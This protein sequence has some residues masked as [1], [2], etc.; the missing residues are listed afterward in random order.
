[1]S[2]PKDHH[3]LVVQRRS[4][5][6]GVTIAGA[7]AM[8]SASGAL[9]QTAGAKQ[10]APLPAATEPKPGKTVPLPN[11][12]AESLPPPSDPVTQTSSGGEFMVD[13]LKALN[14]EYIAINPASCFRGI[15][16]ALINYGKNT[17]PE[18]LTCTHEEIAVAMAHGYA[19]VEGRPMGVLTHGT[20]GLQHAAMAIYNAY[21]DKVPVYVMIGNILAADKRAAPVEWAHAAQD[22]ASIAR[23]YLKWDDQPQSLQHFAESAVR[24][25][26]LAVTAPM[27]PVLLSLD[28]EL[29]ENPIKNRSELKIPK[30]PKLIPAQADSGAVREVARLLVAA[31]NPVL[32]VD[33]VARTPAGMTSLV[34]LAES[35]QCAVV[36]KGGRTN[37]PSRHPLNLSGRAR[38]VIS[39]ADVIVGMELNDFWGSLNTFTDRIERTSASIIGSNAKTI[40][41]G[42]HD[43]F[44]KAN[45]Q[46]FQRYPGVDIDISGDGEATLPVLIEAVKACLDDGRGAAR[47]SRGKKLAAAHDA[48]VL[49]MRR[50]AAL[51]WDAS[52]I[53]MGRLCAEIWE[54]IRHEDW[55]LVGEGIK[56]LAWPRQLWDA[57]RCYR[58]NGESGGFGIGYA[59]PAA[60]GAALAN[61]KHGRLSVAIQG[62]GD[63]MFTP[64]VL[65]TAAHHRI[66]LLY[67]MH[68]NRAYHQEY[69]YV[70]DMCGRLS[71]GIENA[72]IGTTLTDPNIDFATVAKG[73]GVYAEG[74]ITNPAD[75]APALKRAIAVVKQGRP[76]LLDT[77]VE[78]R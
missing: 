69:M 10:V 53:S 24:A 49:D 16:E 78:P 41:I 36:D 3:S 72:H 29:Q 67:V 34:E 71:R 37:F 51:A 22:P 61:R 6:K 12:A 7:A 43:L 32:I 46:E 33:R 4:F 52:P 35:L 73:F 44:L 13:V 26:K 77:I 57:D 60:L 48:A 47:E 63:L 45:Y 62:D 38:S 18:I 21:C 25:Y 68:N 2:E 66:P 55:S 1:M 42:M 9:A 40:S 54:Q 75:L 39:H 65:W 11:Q 17:G 27:G 58:F 28:G 5:L 20:V 30:L 15:H 76:A 74:P 56:Q 70:Q 31:E 23:D 8:G 50:R 14:L 19:K 59:A 64:G